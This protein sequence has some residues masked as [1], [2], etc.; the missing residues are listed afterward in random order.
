M[1]IQ[2]P[3]HDYRWRSAVRKRMIDRGIIEWLISHLQE[4]TD[5]NNGGSSSS[6]EEDGSN[7][8]SSNSKSSYGLEYSTAL[9]MNLCLHKS[10]KERWLS[11]TIHTRIYYVGLKCYSEI[12]WQFRPRIIVILCSN[13]RLWITELENAFVSDVFHLEPKLW[14]QC[15]LG[16][17][18]P[19][20]NRYK[21]I[22]CTKATVPKY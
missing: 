11:S 9:F 2:T 3:F 19:A 1:W 18:R 5:P 15:L 6:S 14:L 20:A 12:S 16:F 10:G 22:D 13:N 21:N 8:S 7:I 17:L 4:R